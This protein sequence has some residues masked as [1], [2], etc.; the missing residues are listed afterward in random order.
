MECHFSFNDKIMFFKYLSNSVNYFEYGSG[1]STFLANSMNNIINIYSVE[2][3]KEWYNNLLLLC[4]KVKLLYNEMNTFPNTWGYPGKNATDYMKSSYSSQILHLS[5]EELNN[6]DLILIDGR[7][8]VA[9]CLKCYNIINNNCKII[10]DDFLNRQE[11]HIILDYYKIIE[12]TD[13]NIM[14]I[15]EKIPNKSI[16]ESLINKYELISR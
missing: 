6:I 1:G 5:G 4:P 16:P 3:D 15:L 14:V 10:V 2:S 9:C 8:R 12:K 13:D 7:F 11:Y